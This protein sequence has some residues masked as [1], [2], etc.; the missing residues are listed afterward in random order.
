MLRARGALLDGQQLD[1]ALSCD[2][3]QPHLWLG[4]GQYVVLEGLL[5]LPDW[6]APAR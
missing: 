3:H 5:G 6:A 4:Y 1:C 2:P